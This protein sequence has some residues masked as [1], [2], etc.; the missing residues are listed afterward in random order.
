MTPRMNREKLTGG[1]KTGDATTEVPTRCERATLGRSGED[2][3]AA[4]LETQGYVIR[5]R[6]VRTR[7]GEIDLVAE[8]NGVIVIVEVKTRS[9]LGAGEPLEA[10]TPR[11]AQRLQRLAAAYMADHGLSDSRDVRIDAIG[12]L[13]QGSRE[14]ID[15][16]EDAV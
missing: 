13:R 16:V 14:R 4:Y 7:L 1:A 9:G 11:K 10:I 15:H 6:N 3:A 12:I 8:K 2:A 5:E